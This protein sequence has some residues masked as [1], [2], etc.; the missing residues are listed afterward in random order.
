[1]RKV[2]EERWVVEEMVVYATFARLDSTAA[3]GNVA[4]TE[5]YTE[6]A[7]AVL[8]LPSAA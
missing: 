5:Q 6:Y 3:R 4:V 2:R 1:M 7:P 8:S